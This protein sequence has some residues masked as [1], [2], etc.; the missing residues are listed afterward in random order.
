[1][2]RARDP[3]SASSARRI[4]VVERH[5]RCAAVAVER[6]Q[7][8]AT[9]CELV[10]RHEGGDWQL[11]PHFTFV[12]LSGRSQP[13]PPHERLSAAQQIEAKLIK[14]CLGASP[15]YFR[16][17]AGAPVAISRRWRSG[18]PTICQRVSS[19]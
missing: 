19:A 15:V 4:D 12:Q 14:R 9:A 7:L 2:P 1:M 6:R 8:V 18:S 17:A 11:S 13:P 16:D 3:K 5:G 10:K